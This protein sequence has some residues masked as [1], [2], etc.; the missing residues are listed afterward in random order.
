MRR[1]FVLALVFTELFGVVGAI[2]C[3]AV[4]DSILPLPMAL[5]GL[6]SGLKLK[7]LA[8]Q[9]KCIAKTN[10]IEARFKTRI[11]LQNLLPLCIG[12]LIAGLFLVQSYELVLAVVTVSLLL[13]SLPLSKLFGTWAWLWATHKEDGTPRR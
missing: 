2:A 6:I 1:I 10:G 13:V 4:P 11:D 5:I 8:I 9:G 3:F 7:S 12:G